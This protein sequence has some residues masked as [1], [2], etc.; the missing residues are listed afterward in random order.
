MK[1]WIKISWD[2]KQLQDGIQ[3]DYILRDHE[4]R[5]VWDEDRW[6][7]VLKMIRENK[8]LDEIAKTFG[9]T[10]THLSERIRWERF[11]L[12]M[13]AFYNFRDA[14]TLNAKL[15]DFSIF[16]D[17]HDHERHEITNWVKEKIYESN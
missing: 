13:K 8:S 10:K 5:R 9:I 2:D 17:K 1:K 6:N 7:Q 3:V 4:N 15:S 11:R 16:T 12:I 14:K